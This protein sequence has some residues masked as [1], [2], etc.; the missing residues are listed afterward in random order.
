MTRFTDSPYE[1]MM[2][3]KPEGGKE[4]FRPPSFPQGHPCYGCKNDGRSW[5]GICHR[6]MA[7][8]LKERRKHHETGN[9]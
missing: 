7:R 3:S 1:R 9:R 2:T 8:W 5:G 6:E 4:T